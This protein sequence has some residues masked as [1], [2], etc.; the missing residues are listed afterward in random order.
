M[1]SQILYNSVKTSDLKAT[2]YIVGLYSS[3]SQ[4]VDREPPV[5]R[6]HLPGGPQARLNISL[7]LR[8]EYAIRK[9]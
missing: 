9:I 2:A 3:G 8:L 7:I 6:C 4:H 5:V 1:Q